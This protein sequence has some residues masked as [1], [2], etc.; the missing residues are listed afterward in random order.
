[1]SEELRRRILLEKEKKEKRRIEQSLPGVIFRRFVDASDIP[2]WVDEELARFCCTETRPDYST[3]A[4]SPQ[5]L[6]RWIEA[7]ARDHRLLGVMLART[8]LENFPWLQ[9]QCTSSGWAKALRDVLGHDLTLLS[10][11]KRRLLVVF[12][13]EYEHIA[14]VASGESPAAG[15]VTWST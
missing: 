13:E 8:G 9:C 12:E 6:G 3:A 4:T 15:T 1:M 5:E 2:G 10:E 14:F 7:L 11:D